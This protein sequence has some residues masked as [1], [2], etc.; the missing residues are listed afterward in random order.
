MRRLSTTVGFMVGLTGIVSTAYG[1]ESLAIH[2][3]SRSDAAEAPSNL[4][5]ATVESTSWM[6][7]DVAYLRRVSLPWPERS[8]FFGAGLDMPVFM[9]GKTGDLDAIRLSV[10]GAA[11]VLR[12]RGFSLVVDLQS[13]LGAQDSVL[14]TSVGWDL[15]LTVAPSLAFESWSVSPLVGLRQ[16]IATY[17]KHGAIV[18]DAFAGRY[19]D[20]VSGAVGPKDGWIAGGN[21]RVPFGLAF[22]VDLARQVALFASAGLVW[23][24]M[25]LGVGMF[26]SMMLGHWPFFVE[27]GVSKRF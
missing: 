26:E 27:L 20:G 13:R 19:A 18:H 7:L 4:V 16:G 1:S 24:R 22:G 2:E 5:A 9:W 23:T 8:V 12:I 10:R 6:S 15:Q 11:E 14:N 25:P 3:A 17:I 21:T